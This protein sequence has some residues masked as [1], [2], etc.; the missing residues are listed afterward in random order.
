MHE[1]LQAVIPGLESV[2][3]TEFKYADGESSALLKF[4]TKQEDGLWP[5]L[6]G[7]LISKMG[8][9]PPNGNRNDDTHHGETKWDLLVTEMYPEYHRLQKA[10]LEAETPPEAEMVGQMIVDR[11]K[12][13]VKRKKWAPF[14]F[15][16]LRHG[17]PSFVPYVKPTG[18]ALEVR[19]MSEEQL[20]ALNEEC[21]DIIDTVRTVRMSPVMNSPVMETAAI[22]EILEG[23][24]DPV[25]RA[26]VSAVGEGYISNKVSCEVTFVGIPGVLM[27]DLKGKIQQMEKKGFRFPPETEL[28]DK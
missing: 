20:E 7:H 22:Q 14:L 8:L 13:N 24:K 15:I 26:I 4:I 16:I 17:K 10:V 11:L 21:Y 5:G 9:L 1:K 27:D 25:K 18:L 6:F 28:P 2:M 23:I 12:G 19:K 3:R